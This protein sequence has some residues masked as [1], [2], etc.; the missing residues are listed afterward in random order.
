[1]TATEVAG[2]GAAEEK[3][4]DELSLHYRTCPLCEATCGLEVAIRDGEVVRIRGDKQNEFSKGFIC[5]KGSTLKHLHDDP[6]RLRRPIVRRGDDPSTATWE[7]VSWP[8]AFAE[9]DRGLRAVIDEHGAESVA[10]Y[11]GNPSAH[12]LSG[13]LYNRTLA[14]ALGTPNVFSA[15]TVDQMPRHVSSGLMYGNPLLI[16]VP[17]L[18]RTDYLLMLGANPYESN[19]SLCTAPDFPGRLEAIKARGG[20]VVVVDPRT[21]KTAEM[22]DEHLAIRPGTDAHLLCAIA[23]RAHRRGAGGPRAGGAAPRRPRRARRRRSRAARPRPS[24]PSAGSTP[25]TSDGSRASSPVPP[26]PPSTAASAPTRSS[27]GRSRAGRA[28]SSRRS[29]A[30]STGRAA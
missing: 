8:E 17:D 12:T 20:R 14:K 28:T 2:A 27:S 7:E 26:A 19:G 23:A 5:P 25:T 15:S 29:R 4:G 24:L 16:A 6:D 30:T 11:F 3:A 13:V 1:M 21:T 10:L 22:A 9:V 18:D